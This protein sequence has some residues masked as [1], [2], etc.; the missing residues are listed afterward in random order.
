MAETKIEGDDNLDEF[1]KVEVPED[2][3]QPSKKSNYTNDWKKINGWYNELNYY[4]KVLQFFGE[5]IKEY[6][7]MYGWWIIVISSLSS[8][9]TLLTFEP[10][11]FSTN[12]EQYYTWGKS[13]V[14]SIL[15]VTTTL[16]AAWI[17]KKNYVKR[18][19]DIDKR[20]NRIEVFKGKLDYQARLVPM[21]SRQDY[22]SFIDELR[23]EYNELSI[24]TNLIS[25]SEFSETV[26]IITKYH[27]L[28]V[29]Y[30]WPWY[31]TKKNRPHVSF[32][33]D[34]IEIYEAQNICST[35]CSH[36]NKKNP[37]FEDTCLNNKNN[38]DE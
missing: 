12:T 24:Y 9:I 21:E 20:I 19:K 37:L 22:L 33:K 1:L 5:S 34:I 4:S 30:Q 13:I 29:K 6:E 25:P 11:D 15:T 14:I 27:P 38:T 18:I 23:D 8:F 31:D 35:C 7:S 36:R 17:K 10:F 32:A 16:I 28:Y 2:V 3:M 26:Y